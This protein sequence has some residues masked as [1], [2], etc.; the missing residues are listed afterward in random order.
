MMLNIMQN[1]QMT[2][3]KIAILS[4]GGVDSSVSIHLLCEQG[5]K[6]DMFYIKIGMIDQDKDFTCTQEE[7]IEMCQWLAKKYGL[8][9]QIVDLQKEYWDGV[10]QY[11][12][13]TVKKGLTPN[14]DVMCN[15]LI[16]FGA[17]NE[18][19]GKDYDYI[20]TGHYAK[21]IV[22][23][24]H[25]YLGTVPDPVKDQTDFLCQLT[26][27]QLQ[28]AMFPIGGLTKEEVR[29]IAEDNKLINAKR[30][31]SQGI[32]FLGKIN[33]NDFI[34]KYL[35]TNPGVIKEYESHK[36]L[37]EHQGLWFHTIGQR[38]GLGLSG[39]PWYVVEKRFITNVLYVSTDKNMLQYTDGHNRRGIRLPRVNWFD[40]CWVDD[41]RYC[42][43]EGYP[44][45]FK[46]RHTPVFHNGLLTWDDNGKFHGYMIKTDEY[47]GGI[48]AGQFCTIYSADETDR[49]CLGSGEIAL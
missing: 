39:G 31:D 27:A 9:F 34:K 20:A 41:D 36:V 8:N 17:F 11:V 13:D 19:Y 30:K 2:N 10:V 28:K 24:G 47:I 25:Q 43:G 49:Y 26:D 44:I 45:T 15:R 35:G 37:G 7:D 5:Y 12:I 23:N 42:K 46:V 4:S 6:P 18:K 38:K 40:W 14:P 21:I 3:T 48:A 1:I 29:K 33:Y 16:K 32:C 22:K